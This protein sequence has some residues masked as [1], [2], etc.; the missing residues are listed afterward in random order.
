MQAVHH[1]GARGLG[2]LDTRCVPGGLAETLSKRVAGNLQLG[3]LRRGILC[4]FT[5]F[6]SADLLVLV[7][8]DGGE[9]SLGEGEGG[10]QGV[11]GGEGGDVHH[12][13]VPVHRVQTH[14]RMRRQAV[15]SN[16]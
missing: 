10:G 15:V 11:A 1:G 13:L 3:D 14:L 4:R 7:S 16:T 6:I 12:G 5:S 9:D 8:R 2:Q